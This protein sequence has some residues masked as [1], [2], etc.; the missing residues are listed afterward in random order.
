MANWED[1]VALMCVTED[2]R[3]RHRCHLQPRGPCPTAP[4]HFAERAMRT[5]RV[6]SPSL[7][8]RCP[9]SGALT[10]LSGYRNMS[11]TLW[12]TGAHLGAGG[13]TGGA[14]CG[15]ITIPWGVSPPPEV[16]ASLQLSHWTPR[17]TPDDCAV[18]AV[19]GSRQQSP[20][21]TAGR[22]CD[23]NSPPMC[24]EHPPPDS[25]LVAE[26]RAHSLVAGDAPQGS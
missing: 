11:P 9:S 3:L 8:P 5:C 7:P 25:R 1:S 16:R 4:G 15:L 12:C 14:R 13:D 22:L 2:G 21:A 19:T 20:Q 24:V 18:A 17:G 23:M 10:R 26:S 6:W